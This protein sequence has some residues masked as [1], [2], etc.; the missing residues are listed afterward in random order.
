LFYRYRYRA[1]AVVDVEFCE[2]ALQ[3]RLYGGPAD[4]E[5]SAD[6]RVAQTARDRRR[7]RNAPP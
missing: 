4:K 5:L 6:L 3:V 1:G 2:E 7:R